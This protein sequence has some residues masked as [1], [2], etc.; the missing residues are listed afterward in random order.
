ME[1]KNNLVPMLILAALFFI[2]G[3]VTWL[4][5]TLITYFKIAFDLNNFQSLLVAWAF[6][7]SYFVMA[8]PSSGI[9]KK[10]GFK[11]GMM[12]G[13]LVMAAG[14]LLFIPAAN[15]QTYGLFL[16]ALFVIGTGLTVLQTASNP[17]ITIVGPIESA[18]SRISMM[19]ICNKLAGVI[20]PTMLS[21]VI[22]SDA[23][24]LVNEIKLLN[25]VD[26]AAR[27]A[28]LLSRVITPYTIMAVVLIALALF[29][30][31]SALP[32]IEMEEPDETTSAL[33][34]RKNIMAYPN[35][36]LGVIALF[37]Y[38][39]AEV[40]AA[41]TIG[42]YGHSQGIPLSESRLFPS[43]TL[44]A[45]VVGYILGIVAIPKFISQSKALAVSAVTGILF[46][47]IAINTTGYTS[48]LFIALMGLA[49]ALM[50]P[51][52][53]PLAIHGLGRFTKTGSALLIMAIIGGGIMS[54]SYGA[55]A[56]IPSIGYRSAY[57]IMIP[58]YLFILFYSIKGHR[59]K[60]WS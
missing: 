13:L 25:E 12:L 40:I 59:I 47:L 15:S 60:S 43:F 7:L 19:G 31:F 10:T 53:W 6:Y 9:L 36:V 35:L 37:L 2:F 55:L 54:V 1:K 21:A 20:A 18:A 57:W 17:Y 48:V 14:A 16:I 26:R 44:A 32:P 56:D 28:E 27:L 41:D 30:R 24:T 8:L 45:M 5:A 49:N 51:A 29:V 39:G 3:F 11:N 42:N 46:S 33:T 34:D 23:D 22:L 50:W 38:V 58:C 52:I 4:N